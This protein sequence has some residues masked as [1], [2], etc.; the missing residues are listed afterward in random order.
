LNSKGFAL[1]CVFSL[2]VFPV[3]SGFSHFDGASHSRGILL[4]SLADQTNPRAL[5]PVYIRLQALE[6][7]N[8]TLWESVPQNFSDHVATI[9]S[10]VL[11]MFVSSNSVGFNLSRDSLGNLWM[12]TDYSLD[13]GEYVDT[14]TWV[15]SKAISENLTSLG[16]VPFPSSYPDD[17]R[18]FLEPGAKIPSEDSAI[19]SLAVAN[20]QTQGNMTQTAKNVL[21]FVNRQGYD[22]E[23]TRLLLSGNLVTSDI[24]DFFKDAL[25][26]HATNSSICVERSWY[27]AAILRAAGVPTRTVTD[28]RLKTWIQIWLPNIGWV[29]AETLCAEPPPYITMLPKPISTAVPWVVENSSDALFPFTWL[30]K[31]PMRLANLT[32]GDPSL[33]RVDRYK[34]VLSQPVDI[35]LFRTDPTKFSFPVAFDPET[36]YASVTREGSGFTLSLIQEDENASVSIIMD[37]QNSLSLGDL[38][39]SFIPV[40]QDG[41]LILYNF[42]VGQVWRFDLRLLLPIVG[43]PVVAVGVWL[44]LRRRR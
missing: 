15:S 3:I 23:T 8:L 22:R 33:F 18:L 26:V 4:D 19:V 13:L 38:L 34:T 17:V 10:K 24:L 40:Q 29:D 20:N 9:D 25:E 5:V 12:V 31:V 43:V 6:S 14:L 36:V 35:D 7:T 1:L 11:A 41:L 44:Y 16:F 2:V 30:P 27:A 39:V 28:I 32:F 42:S 21:D 37:D